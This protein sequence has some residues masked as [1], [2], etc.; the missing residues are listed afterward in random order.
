[1][2]ALIVLC[3]IGSGALG[4][5]LGKSKGRETE[6]VILGLLLGIIG[7]III[8]CM[9]PKHPAPTPQAMWAPAGWQPDPTGRHELRHWDGRAWTSHVSDQGALS[10]DPLQMS[11]Q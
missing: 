3:W 7:V 8:A 10:E 2:G 5:A 1:M 4:F 9:S 11:G 6:G